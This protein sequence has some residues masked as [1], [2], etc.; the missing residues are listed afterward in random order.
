MQWG[1]GRIAAD[2]KAVYGGSGPTAGAA[3]PSS[4]LL[5]GSASS[6]FGMRGSSGSGGA[7]SS[8]TGSAVVS[9]LGGV[10]SVSMA[11]SYPSSHTPRGRGDVV[12]TGPGRR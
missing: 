6:G 9:F 2:G 11:W 4:L 5:V 7:V 1:R 3:P 10:F 12:L 8:D